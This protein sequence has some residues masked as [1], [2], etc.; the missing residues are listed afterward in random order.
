[1]FFFFFFTNSLNHLINLEEAT[2]VETIATIEDQVPRL[3]DE[4]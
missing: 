2:V 3:D 1:M 4:V